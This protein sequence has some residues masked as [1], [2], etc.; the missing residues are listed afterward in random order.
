MT[1][2][3]AAAHHESGHALAALAVGL[4]PLWIRLDRDK[5]GDGACGHRR[6]TDGRPLEMWWDLLIALAGVE[7]E[8]AATGDYSLS[9]AGDRDHRHAE[10]RAVEL[11]AMGMIPLRHLALDDAAAIAERAGWVTDDGVALHLAPADVL[12]VAVA[13]CGRFRAATWPAI[14]ALAESVLANDGELEGRDLGAAIGAALD[15][16][17]WTRPSDPPPAAVAPRPSLALPPARPGRVGPP[18]GFELRAGPGRPFWQPVIP[19]ARR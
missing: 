14:A 1:T 15:G 16:G 9:R 3:S 6:A 12:A 8:R 18:F 10:R 19:T 5:P 11:A 4:G 17:V 13:A 7:A 2:E